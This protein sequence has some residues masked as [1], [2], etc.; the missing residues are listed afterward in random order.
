MNSQDEDRDLRETFASQRGEEEK[1]VT[2]FYPLLEAARVERIRQRPALTPLAL[3]AASLVALVLA[4]GQALQLSMPSTPPGIEPAAS[5]AEWTAPTAF[6]LRTP[7]HDFLSTLPAFARPVPAL[8]PDAPP[9]Q[10][11]SRH[12]SM[13]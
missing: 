6:L 8:N 12:D 3:A 9:K 10:P 5:L 7:G 13:K 1:H 4:V 2:E 11:D